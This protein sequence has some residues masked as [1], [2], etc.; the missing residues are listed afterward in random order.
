MALLEHWEGDSVPAWRD[1]WGLPALEVHDR[2]SS[3]NDRARE[4][5]EAGAVP[6][7]TVL[8]EEQTAGRGRGAAHWVSAA[9]AGLWMTVLLRGGTDTPSYLPLLVGLVVAR[10]VE[11]ATRLSV[12]LE[13]PNDVMVQDR[14]VAGILCEA[15]A[16]T[17][18]VGIGLNVREP[19]GGFPDGL[20]SRAAALSTFDPAAEGARAE[21]AGG[22]LRGLVAV[23][24]VRRARVPDDMLRELGRRDTLLGREV[25]TSQAGRG[26]ARGIAADGSLL[27]EEANG[28]RI[29]I[30]SGSVGVVR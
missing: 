17:T 12:G 29:S 16:G 9:R 23:D 2:L 8:A 11:S 3:T 25:E 30:V 13:W 20:K 1:L 27:L 6:M 26:I 18:L 4:W 19:S 24:A 7:T 5:A 14:K 10:A 15:A 28:N 21:I 22:I